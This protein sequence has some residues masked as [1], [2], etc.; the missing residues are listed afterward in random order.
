MPAATVCSSIEPAKCDDLTA[1]AL[2][3]LIPSPPPFTRLQPVLLLLL[4]HR[5]ALAPAFRPLLHP[6]RTLRCNPSCRRRGSRGW[7]PDRA[8]LW[9]ALPD[10]APLLL[11]SM[12]RLAASS[13]RTRS[14]NVARPL[15][16]RIPE[17]T[18]AP[19]PRVNIFTARESI[20]ESVRMDSCPSRPAAEAQETGQVI[21]VT[22]LDVSRISSKWV[23][24]PY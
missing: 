4:R 5:H 17:T 9:S 12:K 10:L 24:I 14:L 2:L 18:G 11:A 21:V 20:D 23:S 16:E 3:T 1:A 19:D 13:R 6:A 22:T 8:A 7:R 15:T